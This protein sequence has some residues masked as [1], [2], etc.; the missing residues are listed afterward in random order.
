MRAQLAKRRA[1]LRAER[2]GSD[3]V[4]ILL[5]IPLVMF[6][7]LSLIDVSL[8]FQARTTVQNVT[9][10]AAR[11]VAIWGGNNSPLNPTGTTVQAQALNR[12]WDGTKCRSVS[13]SRKP[14]VS[15]TP[16]R[17]TRAGQEVSCTTRFYYASLFPRNPIT[18]FG[19]MTNRVIE[20]TEYARSET[21]FR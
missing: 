16:T 10:D 2:G 6:I 1:K 7:L 8:Y 15:C 3:V 20:V 17:T 13:C 11:E 18:G 21:G 9:R 14:T 12:L 5:T 4:V 19:A